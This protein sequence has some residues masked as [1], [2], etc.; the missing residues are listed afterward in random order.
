MTDQQILI[1]AIEKAG[2]VSA[3]PIDPRN[4]GQPDAD[5]TGG[6]NTTQ[7]SRRVGNRTATLPWLIH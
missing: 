6:V 2:I 3:N 1:E 7:L 5:L 4:M